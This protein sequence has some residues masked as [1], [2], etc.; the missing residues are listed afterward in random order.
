MGDH[1]KIQDFIACK[2][3]VC[4]IMFRNFSSE[5]KMTVPKILSVKA[6][7]REKKREKFNDYLAFKSASRRIQGTGIQFSSMKDLLKIKLFNIFDGKVSNDQ[8]YVI[9]ND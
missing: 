6:Q 8:A 7:S 2:Q 9:V 1:W 4:R 3:E 5:N